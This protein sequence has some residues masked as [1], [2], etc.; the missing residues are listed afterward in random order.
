[1][2]STEIDA[3]CDFH[4]DGARADAAVDEAATVEIVVTVALNSPTNHVNKVTQTEI[5][6][7]KVG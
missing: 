2:G 5:D 4:A 7:A 1:M 6:V 3:A